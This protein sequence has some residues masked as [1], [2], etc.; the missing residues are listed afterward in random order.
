[1]LHWLFFCH[2][3]IEK[4]LKAHVVLSTSEIAPEIHNLTRLAE[5]AKLTLEPEQLK[6][7]DILMIYQL[8][9]RY[10]ENFPVIP[11]TEFANDCLSKTKELLLCLKKKL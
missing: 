2:L 6:L 8:E 11:T 9:G 7:L 1:M 4:I 3:S 10:P 5:K